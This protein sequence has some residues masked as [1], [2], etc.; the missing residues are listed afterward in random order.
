MDHADYHEPVLLTEVVD[1]LVTDCSGIYID[2][3][4]GGGGHSIAILKRLT[5]HGLLIGIDR[6]DEA[7]THARGRLAPFKEQILLKRNSFSNLS[8]IL[9]EERIQGVDGILLDLGLS[10]RQIDRSVRGFSYLSDAPLDMRMDQDQPLTAEIVVND[11]PVTKLKTI[12]RD[13]GE[14]KFAGQIAARIEKVRQERRIISTSQLTEII[15]QVVPYKMRLKS[16]ARVYQSIR[17]FTNDELMQLK[18]V[19]T[20]ILPCLKIHARCVTLAYHSLEDRMIKEFMQSKAN[21]CICP[22]D[23]PVCGCGRQPEIHI[24]TKRAVRPSGEEVARNP[25][26][27]SARMRCIE[28]IR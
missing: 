12:F 11:Y 20:Q 3:T 14:E 26:S 28:K 24:I 27:R 6:D 15:F 10:S 18:S 23:L 17:I 19:L 25:R 7:I 9:E 13:Y 5:K 2:C 16:V 4:I 8:A 1:H 21:P 22:P